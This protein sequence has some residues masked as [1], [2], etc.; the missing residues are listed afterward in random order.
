MSCPLQ[1]RF[2]YLDKIPVEGSNAKGVFGSAIHGALE[3]YNNTGNGEAAEALFLDTWQNP[4][5]IGSP[6]ETFWWPKGMSY[7]SLRERGVQIIRDTVDRYSYIKREVVAAEHPFLVSFGDHELTGYVDLIEV[8][9]SGKG[10]NILSIIDYKTAAKAPTMAELAHDVQMTI[11]LWASLQPEFWFGAIKDG[12]PDPDFPPMRNAEWLHSMYNDLPR[13]AIWYH[14]WNMKEIDAGRRTQEDFD[15]LYR[16]CDEIAKADV[17][18]IHVPKLG[19]A[20][21]L[22]DFRQPCGLSIPTRAEQLEQDD[23]WL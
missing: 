10:K 11:Y 14:L 9:L 7:M 18:G 22:C 12:E 15:R 2:K 4:E 5:K 21:D 19:S 1:A 6:V 3:Y 17:A 8:R 23:A 13:R 16:V 20:C